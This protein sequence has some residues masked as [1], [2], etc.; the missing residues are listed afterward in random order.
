M[1]YCLFK[2]TIIKRTFL[3]HWIIKKF[4]LVAFSYCTWYLIMINMF[5][6]DRKP[7]RSCRT[8]TQLTIVLLIF[9]EYCSQKSKEPAREVFTIPNNYISRPD[10]W[11]VNSI[12]SDIWIEQQ[13]QGKNDSSIEKHKACH[14]DDIFSSPR[15]EN[16]SVQ[17]FHEK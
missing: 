9:T 11:N 8:V 2:S 1:D 13:N 10:K 15:A 7:T 4:L 17:W 16:L 6:K 14:F 5:L 12:L 3:P